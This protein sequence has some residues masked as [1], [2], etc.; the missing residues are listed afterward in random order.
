MRPTIDRNQREIGEG[1]GF[2]GRGILIFVQ[3]RI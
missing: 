3:D 2:I 1:K